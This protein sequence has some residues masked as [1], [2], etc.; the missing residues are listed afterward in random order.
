MVG[1]ALLGLLCGL[2]VWF[3]SLEPDPSVGA[4]PGAE[5]LGTD[6]DRHVG[7]RATVSG[8]IV[9]TEPVVIVDEYGLRE[10]LQLRVVGLDEEVMVREGDHLQ[11]FGVVEADR[12]VRALNAVY[13][14]NSGRLYMFSVSFLAGIW[15]LGRLVRHWRLDRGAWAL[16]PRERAG[17]FG[18][19][20]PSHATEGE[21]DA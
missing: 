5:E 21:R 1:L 18:F 15:V 19:S 16:R 12:T 17:R 10:E 8:R 3:G 13:V 6:Y 20:R 7:E 4:Y 2:G 9:S 11:V 14:P